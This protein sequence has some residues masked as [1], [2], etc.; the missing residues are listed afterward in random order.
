MDS[1]VGGTFWI[2]LLESKHVP[3]WMCRS[4]TS[5]DMLIIARGNVLTQLHHWDG[6]NLLF[7][8]DGNGNLVQLNIEK[9][10]VAT[11]NPQTNLETVG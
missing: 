8:T 7:V 1:H 10:A 11:Y 5:K 3:A 2:R 4:R 9:L 6:A